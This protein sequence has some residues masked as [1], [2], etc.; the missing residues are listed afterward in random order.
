VDY[1]DDPEWKRW[2][3]AALR[4]VLEEEDDCDEGTK[5][6]TSST[7]EGG[8]VHKTMKKCPMTA[9]AASV[10]SS[11]KSG[12]TGSSSSSNYCQTYQTQASSQSSKASS[13]VGSSQSYRTLGSFQSSNNIRPMKPP[14]PDVGGKE[15]N[16]DGEMTLEQKAKAY[17]AYMM[18]GTNHS[19]NELGSVVNHQQPKKTRTP[20]HPL[21]DIPVNILVLT[22]TEEEDDG[23][24][25]LVSILSP[26]T[27]CVHVF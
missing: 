17:D 19:E 12:R 13:R 9:P 21:V 16:N 6:T 7:E 10:S 4:K 11:Q 22:D 23:S 26:L 27:P 1:K 25:T 15:T 3:K 5:G 14:L 20:M 18:G 8:G 24:S 2:R